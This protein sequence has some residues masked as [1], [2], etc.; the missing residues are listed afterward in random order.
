MNALEGSGCVLLWLRFGLCSG[1]VP[2]LGQVCAFTGRSCGERSRGGVFGGSRTK[3]RDTRESLRDS[4][5][6]LMNSRMFGS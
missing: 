1:P 4:I 3:F 2:D 6:V 5:Y